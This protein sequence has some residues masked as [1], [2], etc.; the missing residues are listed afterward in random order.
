MLAETGDPPPNEA[1]SS[2]S[3]NSQTLAAI[4]ADVERRRECRE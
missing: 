4:E 2:S 3:W 1:V